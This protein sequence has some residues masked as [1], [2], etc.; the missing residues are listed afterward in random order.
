MGLNHQGQK[1]LASRKGWLMDE[2][3]A[4]RLVRMSNW[5]APET[6]EARTLLYMAGLDT[7][8]VNSLV[9]AGVRSLADLARWNIP[10]LLRTPNLGRKSVMLITVVLDQHRIKLRG[11][12]DK[13]LT[14][15]QAAANKTRENLRRAGEAHRDALAAVAARKSFLDA[16]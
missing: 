6:H 3:T 2:K 10:D 16:E 11:Q 13:L 8:T 12:D 1:G 14:D 9:N 5:S 4:Q 15:L 7:R